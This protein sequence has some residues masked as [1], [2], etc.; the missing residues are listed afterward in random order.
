MWCC[1]L[2]GWSC[3]TSAAGPS[4]AAG[5]LAQLR[6]DLVAGLHCP[7][8]GLVPRPAP[9]SIRQSFRS[10]STSIRYE[11]RSSCSLHRHRPG[12]LTWCA[13]K[14]ISFT[15]PWIFSSTRLRRSRSSAACLALAISTASRASASASWN[16][17]T[18]RSSRSRACGAARGS[19]CP[20]SFRPRRAVAPSVRLL[21]D[22]NTRIC[23]NRQTHVSEPRPA[24]P[25][26]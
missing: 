18:Y 8:N 23:G 9:A 12:L 24:S 6:L 11:L 10:A 15:E 2:G 14:K 4:G 26:W 16:G 22:D 25:R 7:G 21:G 19:P 17:A 3:R 13:L 20:G 1:G 5:Q